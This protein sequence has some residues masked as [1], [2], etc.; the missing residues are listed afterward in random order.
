MLDKNLLKEII[1]ILM[2]STFYFSLTAR[3]RLNIVKHLIQLMS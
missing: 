2:G 3:E 1:S